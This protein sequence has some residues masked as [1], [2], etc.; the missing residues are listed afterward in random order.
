MALGKPKTSAPTMA[1]M[2]WKVEYHHWPYS[3]QSWAATP[4]QFSKSYEV[5]SFSSD[6][7]NVMRFGMHPWLPPTWGTDPGEKI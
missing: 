3:C 5:W 7:T 1:V 4:P 2:L 6:L